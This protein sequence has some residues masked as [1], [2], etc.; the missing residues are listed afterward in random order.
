MDI[1]VTAEFTVKIQTNAGLSETKLNNQ[2]PGQSGAK[3]VL[4]I[5]FFDDLKAGWIYTLYNK[6]VNVE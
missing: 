2:I 4:C 5:N 1:E 3:V 6:Y